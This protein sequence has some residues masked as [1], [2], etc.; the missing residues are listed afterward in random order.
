[1]PNIKIGDRV[2]VGVSCC[3]DREGYKHLAGLRGKVVAERYSGH[4]G[5]DFGKERH[6]TH[7]LDGNLPEDTGV[8]YL[9]EELQLLSQMQ[10]VN[11]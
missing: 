10:M 5:V 8:W 11:K 2:T 9:R 4:L 7:S 1:M 3:T 6:G